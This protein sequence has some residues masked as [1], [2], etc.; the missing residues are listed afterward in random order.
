MNNIMTD[1]TKKMFVYSIIFLLAITGYAS[2]LRLQKASDAY[3]NFAGDVAAFI[4]D[5][6]DNTAI[7]NATGSFNV[8]AKGPFP[9]SLN[10]ID[11]GVYRID[12]AGVGLTAG[13]SGSTIY[14][15]L[16]TAPG[17]QTIASVSFDVTYTNSGTPPFTGDGSFT[18]PMTPAKTGANFKT[19]GLT[20]TGGCVDPDAGQVTVTVKL[21]GNTN[22]NLAAVTGASAE[23]NAPNCTNQAMTNNGTTFTLDGAAAGCTDGAATVDLM[24][25]GTIYVDGV[26]VGTFDDNA[27]FSAS[28]TATAGAK[29]TI[30]DS[31]PPNSVLAVNGTFAV[32]PALGIGPCFSDQTGSSSALCLHPGDNTARTF[33]NCTKS[34]FDPGCTPASLDAAARANDMAGQ[35]TDTGTM[36]RSPISGG[37]SGGS[38]SIK[39]GDYNLMNGQLFDDSIGVFSCTI[40]DFKS[41]GLF[42]GN[43]LFQ[44]FRLNGGIAPYQFSGT[45]GEELTSL[46]LLTDPEE[47]TVGPLLQQ[48]AQFLNVCD[49]NNACTTCPEFIPG[50]SILSEPEPL[51]TL[52]FDPAPACDVNFFKLGGGSIV[53]AAPGEYMN[54]PE[55]GSPATSDVA[56]RSWNSTEGTTNVIRI[57]H[58]SPSLL[59]VQYNIYS[60]SIDGQV[61]V[62][63]S[64]TNTYIQDGDKWKLTTSLERFELPYKGFKNHVYQFT[65]NVLT[66]MTTIVDLTTGEAVTKNRESFGL[67][68]IYDPLENL[69]TSYYNP[70]F[71]ELPNAV[72]SVPPTP[73]I[74]TIPDA[75]RVFDSGKLVV[76]DLSDICRSMILATNN[77][78]CA[79]NDELR[80]TKT[81]CNGVIADPS[82][83]ENNAIQTPQTPTVC[84]G[85]NNQKD[86]IDP[87]S[88]L[89]GLKAPGQPQLCEDPSLGNPNGDL[90]EQRI[91]QIE[92][93]EKRMLP[94][95]DGT[96]T[97]V[98]VP[99]RIKLLR[100]YTID[101]K[102]LYTVTQ[103]YMFDDGQW[104]L[105]TTREGRTLGDDLSRT[106][107]IVTDNLNADA[108]VTIRR[109]E[110][111]QTIVESYPS[112]Q[113]SEIRKRYGFSEEEP[114]SQA[115]IATQCIAKPAPNP[116]NPYSEGFK[117]KTRIKWTKNEQGNYERSE[118]CPLDP[119]GKVQG[120]GIQ[121]AAVA[122]S[123]LPGTLP[124]GIPQ[125]LIDDQQRDF[126]GCYLTP[127]GTTDP[128][129]QI[130]MNL[131]VGQ[132]ASVLE[133]Y[134]L[135]YGPAKA[136]QM[137]QTNDGWTNLILR[138]TGKTPLV[139]ST[140]VDTAA[141]NAFYRKI[142][143]RN[144]GETAYD[145]AAKQVLVNGILPA[146]KRNLKTEQEKI[147]SFIALTGSIPTTNLHWRMIWVLSYIPENAAALT[148]FSDA[149][150]Q[151][152]SNPNSCTADLEND[153]RITKE[154]HESNIG[155][156]QQQLNGLQDDAIAC[157][158]K[159]DDL[160][161]QI[162]QLQSEIAQLKDQIN[163]EQ[164]RLSAI[165]GRIALL[166]GNIA[167]IQTALSQQG[168]T[169]STSPKAGVQEQ[170]A[171]LSADGGNTWWE[172]SG[173]DAAQ[174]LLD[175]MP[176]IREL[177]ANYK[178][179]A[180][181][182]QES[183]ELANQINQNQADL[184]TK[185]AQLADLLAQLEEHDKKCAQLDK[186]VA[187]V[188]KGLE[189]LQQFVDDF[190]AIAQIC[191]L[192]LAPLPPAPGQPGFIGPLPKD[193]TI[194]EA[195][196]GL[197]QFFPR[198]TDNNGQK[199]NDQKY[200]ESLISSVPS[201]SIMP[202]IID[203]ATLR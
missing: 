16:V 141:A 28:T 93:Y 92:K 152:Q 91:V 121:V 193:P 19:I 178:E 136:A 139:E 58:T 185:L 175:L 194:A 55:P 124:K 105:Q 49:A 109:T 78:I 96:L 27:A 32:D 36:D 15:T 60:Y 52:A 111:S 85:I 67:G 40:L 163:Q 100:I 133:N 176:Q 200:F 34:S 132:R 172:A 18:P 24:I 198:P 129:T 1:K 59:T 29:F 115:T 166:E 110:G 161:K 42:P 13:D 114:T 125:E 199:I 127:T 39:V 4:Y 180:S 169:S 106:V 156:I 5:A 57:A 117:S 148:S 131:G 41:Q 145:K 107:A 7:N 62:I 201:R 160:Q 72:P 79:D 71:A 48:E 181:L 173:S 138:A 86:C 187:A 87:N 101:G 26:S 61:R 122:E 22:V 147:A 150:I 130:I 126:I 75:V 89:P 47:V 73:P 77:S 170:G 56:E 17:Y 9:F 195:V 151:H 94:A 123:I 192:N 10:G 184:Q 191:R 6:C 63:G 183:T 98:S 45:K 202:K 8:G 159:H 186:E 31:A 154:I 102:I 66:K 90:K 142:T 25:P 38:G 153:L 177:E 140:N 68:K 11:N 76:N 33:T 2:I 137:L 190:N 44:P 84:D 149:I 158:K 167:S 196:K 95:P 46:S 179:L 144:L 116:E 82:K 21:N 69:P 104:K 3:A 174:K 134:Y 108:P 120:Q 164:K 20:P 197:E 64:T 43:A 99:T 54:V 182:R 118:P 35:V 113:R 80:S 157:K 119:S 168:L 51:P 155:A 188:K 23:F 135:A 53:Q 37:S 128:E 88:L 14:A 162:D 171:A 165:P 203:P 70:C 30:T 146:V 50:K 143:G 112:S 81:D 74:V 103:W 65:T 97:E 12:G 189:D 83:C